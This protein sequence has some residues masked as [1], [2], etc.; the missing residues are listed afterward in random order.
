MTTTEKKKQVKVN[1]YVVR[2][3]RARLFSSRGA[4]YGK[5]STEQHAWEVV[6]G[7][8]SSHAAWTS[9]ASRDY[10]SS[11]PHT[12]PRSAIC[13]TCHAS[14]DIYRLAAR[15]CSRGVHPNTVDVDSDTLSPLNKGALLFIDALLQSGAEVDN[16]RRRAT[17][18]PRCS[19]RCGRATLPW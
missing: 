14:D 16:R 3:Q 8:Q 7:A 13:T 6:R 15:W 18:P 12:R 4:K 17:V 10:F 2:D 5:R 9:R 11:P 1:E 19:S